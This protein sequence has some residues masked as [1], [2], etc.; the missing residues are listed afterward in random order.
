[1]ADPVRLGIFANRLSAIAE[2][3]GAV[4]QRA[5]LSPNIRDRLDYSCALFDSR[6]EL[7]AQ[8]AHIP[9]HLGSMAFAMQQLVNSVEWNPGDAVIWNDPFRG[10]THLPDVT[11][12]APVF[13]TGELVGFVANR[14]HH[15]DIGSAA[16]GSMPLS[17]CL[18]AEGVLISPI[19]IARGDK[20]L[21]ETFDSLTSSLGDHS[22]GDFI[23]QWSACLRGV[24]RF[25]QLLESI[26][27]GRFQSDSEQLNQYAE[28]LAGQVMQQVAPGCWR[29]TELMDSDG[30]GAVDIPLVLQLT[31]SKQRWHANFDGT[32]AQVEGNLN[33]PLSVTMAALFYVFRCLLPAQTPVCA[34]LFRGISIQAPAGSLVNAEYPA[35]VAAGNVETSQRI[36]DLVLQALRKA[37]V[38]NLPADSQGTMNNLAMGGEGSGTWSYY[39]TVAGGCGAHAR[40]AGLDASQSHMTNTL[41][42]PVESFESSFPVRLLRYQLRRGSGGGGMH[43]GGEGICREYLFE[44]DTQVSLITERRRRGP[45]GSHGGGPGEPG[46]NLVD[47]QPVAEKFSAVLRAGQRLTLNTPGGGGWGC[48][49]REN[50]T[51]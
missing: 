18:E 4:L 20:L 15:A 49:E 25:S 29:A 41:N 24:E 48:L 13:H 34:G 50:K 2:E 51:K 12:A 14:A 10:G 28:S 31:T 3:M 19:H 6:G 47:G 7:L 35:A 21:Q 23:A 38:E 17:N 22:R 46:L 11:L 40:A 36:V 43:R 44:Q 45:G 42:T 32:S 8:A 1:M 30:F 26:G 5:A 37:G 16:P 39:E 27:L 33:C 9:V